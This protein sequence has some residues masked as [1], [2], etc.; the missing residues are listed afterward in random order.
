MIY[1]TLTAVFSYTTGTIP[2]LNNYITAFVSFTLLPF[3]KGKHKSKINTCLEFF[4]IF[5]L[6]VTSLFS[7]MDYPLMTYVITVMSI[8]LSLIVFVGILLY[9]IVIV[10]DGKCGNK[11]KHFKQFNAAASQ[12]LLV[13]I[14]RG[15]SESNI[16][17]SSAHIINRRE[18]LIYDID[19]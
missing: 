1:L 5:N 3:I 13:P 6:G 9:H 8:C 14:V 2:Y 15:E 18:S 7:I 17:E 12:S 16:E 4:F 11:L 10:M 19:L